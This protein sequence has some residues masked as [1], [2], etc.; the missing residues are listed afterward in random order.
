MPQENYIIVPMDRLGVTCVQKDLVKTINIINSF[1]SQKK[2]VYWL[3]SEAKIHTEE[4]PEGH[5]FAPGAFIVKKDTDIIEILKKGE[6]Y[7]SGIVSDF[8]IENSIRLSKKK[9]ALYTGKGAA[10]F[11]LNPLIEVI[12]E[13]GFNY[14]N[15]NDHDIRKG[16]LDSFDILIVPGGPDAGESYYHGLGNKGYSI[17]KEYISSKG[18]YLGIC[19]GA[20][21]PLTSTSENNRFW[22]NLVDATD[23]QELDYWRT[24]TGFLRIKIIENAHPFAFG[25]T[26]GNI[27][28]LDMVYWEGPAIKPLSPK[29]KSLAIFDDFIASGTSTDYPR[30]DLLDNTPAK[31]AINNWYNILTRERFNKYL[32]NFSAV[33]ETRINNN[34]ILLYSPHAE[35]GNI[36]IT[37]R[38]YSQVYLLISNGLFYLSF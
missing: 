33:I 25:L 13:M 3:T 6:V 37:Q 14:E 19:A 34:K 31:D 36:G 17:L 21:L 15:V 7:F 24:G 29:V 12:R 8:K 38:K 27:N 5:F 1:I 20:Y 23:E 9:I 32:K 10:E 22:L 16:L 26:A 11:C 28:T 18:N 35:F 4:F 30:W 2:D